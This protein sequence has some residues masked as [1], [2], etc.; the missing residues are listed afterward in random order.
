MR[1]D[2][3]SHMNRGRL[4]VVVV[5]VALVAAFFAFDLDRYFTFEFFK[6]RQLEIESS[7]RA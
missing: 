7:T 2:T 3:L 1:R 4:A 6:S 5:I